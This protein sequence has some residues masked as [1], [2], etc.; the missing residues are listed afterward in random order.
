MQVLIFNALLYIITAAFFFKKDRHFTIRTLI[1]LLY[2]IFA[3]A[4]I[5]TICDGTFY[6]TF[7]NY[8]LSKL[9]IIPYLGNYLLILMMTLSIGNIGQ[10]ALRNKVFFVDNKIINLIE[11]FVIIISLVYVVMLF[12]VASI[13]SSYDLGE[14]YQAAHDGDLIIPFPAQWMNIAYY[15]TM[16]ILDILYPVIY[17]I[18]F[19]KLSSG[20]KMT[21]SMMIVLLILIPRIMGCAIMAN[22]GGIIFNTAS[23]VFFMIFFWNRLPGRVKLYF[24]TGSAWFVALIVFYLAAISISRLGDDEKEAGNS[25]L[26]YFGEAFPN[27]G[28]RVWEVSDHYLMGM[29]TFPTV[30]SLFE[31]IPNVVSNAEGNGVKHIIFEN[32]SGFPI[33]NFKTFYGDLYCEWG[34]ILPFII[35]GIYLFIIKSFK[36][37]LSNSVF[38][39]L[40]SYSVYMAIIWGLFNANKICETDVENTITLFFIGLFLNNV[41]KKQKMS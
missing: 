24:K 6:S 3:I 11:I 34:P 7:G 31:P 15:R 35:I 36:K 29:R 39:L 12:V 1:F 5:Y 27:L 40:M 14:I 19:M 38:S 2:S 22:R 18:E 26:R 25:V 41:V 20:K 32:I 10:T 17:L 8:S 30:Y 13:L 23:F 21:R 16:Q 28:L 4:G 33:I 9:N 37:M